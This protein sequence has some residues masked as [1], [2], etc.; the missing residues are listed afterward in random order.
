MLGKKAMPCASH[1]LFRVYL[2]YGGHVMRAIGSSEQNFIGFF[3]F[4]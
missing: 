2:V 1:T 3:L 4:N